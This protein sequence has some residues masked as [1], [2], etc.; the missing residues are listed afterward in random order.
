MRAGGSY[1]RIKFFAKQITRDPSGASVDTW[2]FSTA[3]ITT[4]GEV[5]YVGGNFNIKTEEKFYS[6]NVELTVRYRS[7]ITE[8]MKV[9]IDGTADV[10]LITYLEILGR[11][12][13]LKLT[14]EK[15]IEQLPVTA[16]LPPTA[17][18]ATVDGS[19]YNRINLAWTNNAA[20]DGVIIER[21]LNGND[22]TEVVRIPKAVAPASS[23]TTYANTGLAATT[24]YYYRIR[25]FHYYSFS[26]YATV[27]L[28]TTN[29]AP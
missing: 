15:D 17:F 24:T 5:R 11:Y 1:H 16:V 25:A 28:A 3:T 21:S 12:E 23:V 13:G 14:I 4:R 9:R 26:T 20:A 29:A 10:W 7:A 6:K 8:T 2:D 18:T 19:I 27:K 22:F